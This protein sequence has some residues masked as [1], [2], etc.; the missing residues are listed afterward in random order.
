MS[1]SVGDPVSD[2]RSLHHLWDQLPS[3]RDHTSVAQLHGGLTNVNYLLRTSTGDVV[4][5]LSSPDASLLA[6]DRDIE[7]HNARAAF[8]SGVAPE[9]LDRL[10]DPPVLV[11]R[12][13]P[14]TT[15]DA[16]AVASG[17]YTDE[18]ARSLRT[19]HHGP[20]FRSRFDMFDIGARYL[21]LALDRGLDLPPRYLEHRDTIGRIRGA[22]AGHPE[23]LVSCHNDLLAEN[24]LWDGTSVHI[25]DFEYSGMNEPS[26]ELGNLAA[27]SSVT[28]PVLD[29]LI[30]A[31]WQVATD[32]PLVVHKRARAQ[33][34]GLVA[35]YGWTLWALISEAINPLD[36]DFRGWGMAKYDAFE[37]T[38]SQ[39]G[40]SANVDL[41]DVIRHAELPIDESGL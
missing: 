27:E 19:L 11:V 18:I 23:P 20:A 26:F 15:L 2:S 38:V 29:E 6:I 4:A 39:R 34:W 10:L 16:D 36:F 8:H 25:I 9:V 7:E 12:Y 3:C 17:R 28:D 32:H 13:V 41:D 22:L 21:Q 35:Q 37:S 30:A 24:F 14:S 1:D 40:P 5:R 31:Y 33:L